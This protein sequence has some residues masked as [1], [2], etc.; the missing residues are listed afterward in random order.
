MTIMDCP[1]VSSSE[2]LI[3]VDNDDEYE[4]DEYA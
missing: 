3:R 4:Y 1:M 2:K